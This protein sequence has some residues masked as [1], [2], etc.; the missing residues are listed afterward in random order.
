[1]D[2]PRRLSTASSSGE[3]SPILSNFNSSTSLILVHDDEEPS[4]PFA[5]DFPEDDE[6]VP[7]SP[8]FEIRRPFCPPMA[9][10]LVFLYLLSPY[11]KLGALFL[12]NTQLPLKYGIPP[13]FIFAVLAAFSRQIW[14][15]LARYMRKADLE[16]IILDAFARGRGRERQRAWLRA[17]VR[18]GTG[19]LRVLLA[20]IY[21]R[22]KS[23]V[24]CDVQ[25]GEPWPFTGQFGRLLALA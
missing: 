1:M 17:I 18:G 14:Y 25:A 8:E 10:S 16:D 19:S 7:E 22:G 6:D 21:L 23:V 13:L 20:V 5:F 15:M 3:S 9:P 11:L 4:S 12:P 24:L 2:L